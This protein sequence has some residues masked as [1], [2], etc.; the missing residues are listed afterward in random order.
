MSTPSTE[1]AL[2]R[3]LARRHLIDADEPS[4]L[5]S[6]G[7]QRPPSKY[8]PGPWEAVLAGVLIGAFLSY[9]A[10]VF[11]DNQ[12]RTPSPLISLRTGEPSK[13]MQLRVVATPWAHVLVDGRLRETT[14]FAQPIEL[15]PG[16]H[17]VRLEHPSAPAEERIV[18]GQ[19]GQ[20]ILLD[21]R[22]AVKKPIPEVSSTPPVPVD[23]SP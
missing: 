21:V 4:G 15:E 10:I 1:G 18:E 14:P 8:R 20:A 23:D 6:A 16:R 3:E 19:A 13:K 12:E 17:V 11:Q 5:A 7:A 22:M 2:R 9:G